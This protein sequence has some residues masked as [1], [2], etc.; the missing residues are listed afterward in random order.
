MF[1]LVQLSAFPGTKTYYAPLT[2]TK[3]GLPSSNILAIGQVFKADWIEMI[4]LS[5]KPGSLNK[6]SLLI[7]LQSST[8]PIN[9]EIFNV[10]GSL[11]EVSS[12][13]SISIYAGFVN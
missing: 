3:T 2:H 13:I 4:F 12:Q 7:K 1:D 8:N 10:F 9:F 5:A 11:S 6:L